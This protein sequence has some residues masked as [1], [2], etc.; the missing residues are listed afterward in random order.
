SKSDKDYTVQSNDSLYKISMK[1][2][3]RGDKANAIYDLNKQVI[4]SDPAKLKVGMVLKVPQAA[5]V[6]TASAAH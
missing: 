3:G 4:G 6:T 5:P 2:F 1:L